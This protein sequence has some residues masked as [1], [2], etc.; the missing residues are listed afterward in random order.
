M[1][2]GRLPHRRRRGE[3][4]HRGVALLPAWES[5]YKTYSGKRELVGYALS[6]L[7]ADYDRILLGL[8]E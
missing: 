6:L 2:R 4:Q 3:E 1:H 8:S 7:D 5:A